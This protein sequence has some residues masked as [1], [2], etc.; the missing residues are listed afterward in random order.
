MVHLSALHTR[1]DFHVLAY[2]EPSSI[3]I[4]FSYKELTF[5]GVTDK[6]AVLDPS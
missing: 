4:A 2:M 5:F 6:D 3:S 1:C